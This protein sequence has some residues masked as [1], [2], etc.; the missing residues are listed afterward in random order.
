LNSIIQ[1]FAENLLPILI[2]AG[3]GFSLQRIFSINPRPVSQ[4]IFNAFTPSLIFTLLVNSDIQ[5]SNMGRMVLLSVLVAF[6]IGII[7][8]LLGRFLRLPITTNSAFILTAIGMNAGNFGLSLNYFAFGEEA[9]TWASIFFVTN[10]L[11]INSAGVYIATVGKMKPVQA[12]KGLLKVPAIYSIPL[13]FLVRGFELDIPLALWRPI[14]LMSSASIPCMLIILGMQISNNGFPK[15][16]GLLSLTSALRLLI[17]PA[18]AYLFANL[19]GFTGAAFQAGVTEAAVPTAVI[20]SIIA[21]EF[22]VDPSYVTGAILVT[23][24][25]SPISITPLLSLLGA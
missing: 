11:L 17:S 6:F 20:T 16:L 10:S 25:L 3:I 7:A 21:L 18:I 2:V 15:R 13:A 8:W 23:T 1:L 14:E 24:L 9:L 19:L 4:I 12:L 22:D 5:A